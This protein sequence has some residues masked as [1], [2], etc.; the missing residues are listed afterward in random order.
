MQCIGGFAECSPGEDSY[1]GEN[2]E[3][4][5]DTVSGDMSKSGHI[6]K[7]DYGVWVNLICAALVNLYSPQSGKVYT[8]GNLTMKIKVTFQI[9]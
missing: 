7:S 9:L 1:L 3:F 4:D 8:M 6:T 2:P 5:P